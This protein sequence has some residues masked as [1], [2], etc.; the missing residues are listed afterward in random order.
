MILDARDATVPLTRSADVAIVGAG[1]SGM[2]LARELADVAEVL[3]VEGGGVEPDAA[4][5]SLHDGESVGID[6]PLTTT[7]IRQFGGSS[8]LWAGYCAVFDPHDF[9]ARPWVP[10]SGWPLSFDDVRHYYPK[11]ARLLNLRDDNFDADDITRRAGVCVPFDRQ[12][13]VATAWRFG[14]P[15]IRFGEQLRGEFESTRSVTALTHANL[16]D[17]RLDTGHGAVSELCIRTMDGREGCVRARIFVLACGGIETARQLL[18]AN[19]QLGQGLGNA[20][21]MVGRCFMEHPHLAVP[22]VKLNDTEAFRSWLQPQSFDGEQSFLSAVGLSQEAQEEARILNARAHVYR[23]P[24]MSLDDPPRL[25]IF[26]EQA[27]NRRS[28]LVLSETRDGLDTRRV[29]LDWQLTALDWRT[30]RTTA[31]A[32]AREFAR[33]GL[34]RL[35]DLGALDRMGAGEVLHSNHHLGT[36]RM[37]ASAADGVVDPH[38]RVHDLENLYIAGG[39]VFPTVSWANPTLTML[40]LVH[41]LATHLRQRLDPRACRETGGRPVSSV[42][43]PRGGLP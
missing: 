4:L 35:D 41:R 19:S 32:L 6:Y 5:Q 30:Y 13:F 29:R 27:P 21:G 8:N 11:A 10:D 17:I 3:V 38:C 24:R 22:C 25:G 7:R 20:Q 2:T 23:T 33:L 26:L 15:T 43:D 14:S 42:S 36:T 31:L 16:V 12:R 39:G 28:R 1:P 37:S 18:N 34:G 9:D 40:A